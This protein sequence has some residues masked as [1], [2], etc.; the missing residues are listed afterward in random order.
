MIVRKS[1]LMQYILIYL[2]MVYNGGVLYYAIQGEKPV[3]IQMVSY[4]IVF[5]GFVAHFFNKRKY[6]TQYCLYISIILIVSVILVR[7]T[8]GGVGISSLIDYLSCIMLAFLAVCV[9]KDKFSMRMINVV[10]CFAGIS[11]VCYLV[12]IFSPDILKMLL[13]SFD[14][15]FSYNDWSAAAYGG[16]VVKVSYTAWGKLLF[17]M[18]EGEMARNLG[19]FTEPGNYQIVLNCT[20][21]LLLF[22]PQFHSF[23][24]KQIGRRFIIITLAVLTT[25][26]TSGYLIL[27]SFCIAFFFVKDYDNLTNIR[28]TL[29]GLLFSTAIF[30][31]VDYNIRGNESLLYTALIGKLFSEGKV[32]MTAST[33]VWRLST[34]GTS[35]LIMILHPLGIGFD[36]TFSTIHQQLSGSAGGALMAFGAALGVIPFFSTIIWH[37]YPVM[38]NDELTVVAKIT[39]MI[40]FFQSTIA[41]SKVFYPFIVS[42]VVLLV[43]ARHNNDQDYEDKN[44]LLEVH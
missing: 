33:G 42:I 35:V 24:K 15:T 9:D 40:L 16:S 26:S 37:I 22:L 1:A 43:V 31:V 10:Y 23:D 27:L 7:Y 4:I 3:Y 28:K 19:I 13:D 5:L 21:F 17:T 29:L 2:M 41:Q 25:Q 34:M 12:Q 20:L 8:A 11:V 39:F 6:G 32:D 14:S 36:S 18:R 30:L 38:K 44:I